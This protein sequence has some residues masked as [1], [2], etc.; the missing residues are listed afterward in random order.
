MCMEGGWGVL[1]TDFQS[2][3]KKTRK[4]SPSTQWTRIIAGEYNVALLF[5]EKP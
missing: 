5:A 3:S 1:L 4:K 2:I